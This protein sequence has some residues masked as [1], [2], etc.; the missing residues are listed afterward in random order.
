MANA[1]FRNYIAG[2]WVA[3]ATLTLNRNPSDVSDVIGEYAQADV[4]QTRAAIAARA[5]AA[6]ACA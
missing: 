1:P 3:G 2:E 6:S 4:A 5:C